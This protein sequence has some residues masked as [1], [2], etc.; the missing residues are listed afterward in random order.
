MAL[1]RSRGKMKE[2]KATCC[3]F[4]R[5]YLRWIGSEW[6]AEVK[7]SAFPATFCICGEPLKKPRRI[8]LDREAVKMIR[9]VQEQIK[10]LKNCHPERPYED[11]SGA[12]E[13]EELLSI[14]Q[15]EGE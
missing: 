13:L 15:I 14:A 4:G 3:G 2:I 5:Q 1:P 11:I 10:R 6:F 9:F 8:V 7:L 12:N